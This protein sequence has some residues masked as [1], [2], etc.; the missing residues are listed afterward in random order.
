M[1]LPILKYKQASFAVNVT[2][3]FI[4]ANKLVIVGCIQKDSDT[5]ELYVFDQEEQLYQ[6]ELKPQYF[7]STAEELKS[8]FQKAKV[9]LME[10]DNGFLDIKKLFG[11]QSGQQLN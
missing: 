4:D 1:F 3:T 10:I 6:E 8:N 9:L 11:R 7:E 2:E 5:C